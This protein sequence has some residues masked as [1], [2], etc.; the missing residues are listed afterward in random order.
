MC[1]YDWYRDTERRY[2]GC[3]CAERRGAIERKSETHRTRVRR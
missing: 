2:A 1:L 3:R